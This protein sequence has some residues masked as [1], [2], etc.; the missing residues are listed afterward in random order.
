MRL[1]NG[2]QRNREHPRTFIIPDQASV[3]AIVPGRHVKVGLEFDPAHNRQFDFMCEA[4]KF[5]VEVVAVEGAQF[6]GRVDNDLVHSKQH[7]VQYGDLIEFHREN[8]LAILPPAD[9][10]TLA[11][12]RPA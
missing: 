6:V 3:D 4:E 9:V 10:V 11:G 8:I 2:L 7:G 1:I 5:W 12:R